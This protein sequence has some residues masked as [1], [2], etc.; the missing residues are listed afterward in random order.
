MKLFI[1]FHLSAIISHPKFRGT[2]GGTSAT[3]FESRCYNLQCY[4]LNKIYC[5]FTATWAFDVKE[6]IVMTIEFQLLHATYSYRRTVLNEEILEILQ[7]YV[8]KYSK[9]KNKIY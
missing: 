6:E 7:N 1:N 5:E 9:D 2:P 4:Q 8:L 3:I